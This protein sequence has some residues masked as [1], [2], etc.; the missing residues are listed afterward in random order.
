MQRL[1]HVER[2]NMRKRNSS[3]DLRLSK[4]EAED[5]RK[6]AARAG[7]TIQTYFLWMLY[8]HPIREA[9]PIEY[10]EVLRQLRQIN[11]SM[12]QIAVK[13]SEMKGIDTTAY[14]KNIDA[15]QKSI[16]KIME[17]VYG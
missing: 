13:A 10:Q 17:G 9:P 16:G 12:N 8:N 14:W 6:K 1:S 15:L 11:S 3:V 5:F 7:V 2:R 4:K